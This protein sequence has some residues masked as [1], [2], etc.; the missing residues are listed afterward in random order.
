MYTDT[1]T[2]TKHLPFNGCRCDQIGFVDV[3]VFDPFDKIGDGEVG[4]SFFGLSNSMELVGKDIFGGKDVEFTVRSEAKTS[5]VE[6]PD[7]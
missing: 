5:C 1:M 3:D 6:M 2:H 4:I 7:F